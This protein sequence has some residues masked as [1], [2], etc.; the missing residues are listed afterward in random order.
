ML[1]LLNGLCEQRSFLAGRQ[2]T[3]ADLAAAAQLSAL[4]YFGDVPWDSVPDLREWFVRM[5]SRPCFRG[6]LADRL[7]GTQPVAHYADLDF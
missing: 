7:S 3:V 6:L 4:D 2:L 1:T 5:K